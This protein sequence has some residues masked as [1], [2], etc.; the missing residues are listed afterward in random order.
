MSAN[1]RTAG[2]PFRLTSRTRRSPLERIQKT[3]SPGL[4]SVGDTTA[5]RKSHER[6]EVR[7]PRIKN[8]RQFELKLQAQLWDLEDVEDFEVL[9]RPDSEDSGTPVTTRLQQREV[10]ELGQRR[11]D[12]RKGAGPANRTARKIA[13]RWTTG[14]VFR[15]YK[16]LEASRLVDFTRSASAGGGKVEEERKISAASVVSNCSVGKAGTKGH[17]MSG[18]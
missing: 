2:K 18:A 7:E 1:G 8:N 6:G 17:L 4:V 3:Q 12:G 9:L 16:P 15:K 10:D 14:G 5:G 13:A 11:E